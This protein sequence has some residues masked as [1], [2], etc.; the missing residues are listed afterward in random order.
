MNCND[1]RAYAAK[2][3]TYDDDNPS[4]NMAMTSPDA[5][6]WKNA[7]VKEIVGFLKQN[8]WGIIPQASVPK[9]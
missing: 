7:M 5:H 9:D 6:L 8:A 2:F 1:S 4:F 3:K